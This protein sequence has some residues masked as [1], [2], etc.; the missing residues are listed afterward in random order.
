MRFIITGTIYL[1]LNMLM[2]AF[3]VLTPAHAGIYCGADSNG[4]LFCTDDPESAPA[5]INLVER[6]GALQDF[7]RYTHADAAAEPYH[8]IAPALPPLPKVQVM[9][10]SR[11]PTPYVSACVGLHQH[12]WSNLP[13]S[14]CG[15]AFG[16]GPTV[17]RTPGIPVV[18]HD[19]GPPTVR[20]QL[21]P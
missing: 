21:L 6:G 12:A 3:F 4:I 2:L 10:K 16:P 14:D 7:T 1:I 19:L 17:N 20:I 11:Q 15:Q 5:S 18:K 9:G 8:W 13:F